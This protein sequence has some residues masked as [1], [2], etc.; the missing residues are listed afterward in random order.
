MRLLRT[1]LL[2][3]ALML[4]VSLV[5]SACVAPVAPAETGG[6][7][8]Q[9]AAGSSVLKVGLV[10]DVG[11]VNDRS[12]NQSAWEGVKQAAEALGLA[13][14]EFKYIE[15]MDAKDYADNMQQFIDADYD[16]IVHGGIRAWRSDYRGRQGEPRYH[17]HRHRPVP[18]RDDS[19]LGR[20]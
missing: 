18:R 13:E 5:L 6:G 3:V 7:E 17:V 20:V 4:V 16:V 9:D 1:P 2:L 11:R 10:T 8:S 12:F 14:D 19:E 15:T